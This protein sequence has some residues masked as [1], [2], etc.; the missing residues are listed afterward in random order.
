MLARLRL[1]LARAAVRLSAPA[2]GLQPIEQHEPDD[3]FIVGFPKSGHTWLQYQLAGLVGGVDA[4]RCPDALVQDL[5]PDI[6]ARHAYRRY[7]SPVFFKSHVPTP[8][9]DYRR[10]IYLLRDGRDAMVSWFHH[11]NAM[12]P[13]VDFST[14]IR[15]APHLEARWHEHVEAWLANP[16]GAEILTVRYEDMKHDPVGQL[17][18][19]AEFARIQTDD[20]QLAR[21]VAG[22]GFEQQKQREARQGWEDPKWPKDKSFVRRGA[23]GSFRDEFPPDA[24]AL[25]LAE[26]GPT[27]KKLGYID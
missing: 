13:P 15:T 25:F 1:A 3:V 4:A 14:L 6:H 5:I 26:A 16:H 27:L 23:V 20:T 24:L 17:R 18:R 12:F 19:I 21:A 11:H 22:A 7:T 10:V 9:P 8:P 2:T